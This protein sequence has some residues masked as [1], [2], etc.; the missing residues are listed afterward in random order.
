[1]TLLRPRQWQ[2]VCA[3]SH[4]QCSKE[5]SKKN[6]CESNRLYSTCFKH[7]STLKTA[8][9]TRPYRSGGITSPSRE[10]VARSLPNRNDAQTVSEMKLRKI[11]TRNPWLSSQINWPR[12]HRGKS[13]GT[14]TINFHLPRCL[15]PFSAEI[16]LMPGITRPER[17][18][19]R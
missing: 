11:S 10:R 12:I 4:R 6:Q 8:P 9:S 7:P 5:L 14:P 15:A 17:E 19:G 13:T 18:P 16:T 2:K 1:M 3:E